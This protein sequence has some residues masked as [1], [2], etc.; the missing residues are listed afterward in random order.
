MSVVYGMIELFM[1]KEGD[2]YIFRGVGSLHFSCCDVGGC[3]RNGNF[4]AE[5]EKAVIVFGV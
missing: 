3:R 1:K 2:I 4:C 5:I